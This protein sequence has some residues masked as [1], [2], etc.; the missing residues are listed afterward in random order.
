MS[1]LECP[2][3][4]LIIRLPQAT[5]TLGYWALSVGNFHPWVEVQYTVLQW[6][7]KSFRG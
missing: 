5:V 1:V 7:S 2:A 6:W 3:P 4:P